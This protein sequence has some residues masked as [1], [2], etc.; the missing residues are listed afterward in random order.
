M[1]R[2]CIGSEVKG[3]GMSMVV[4]PYFPPPSTSNYHADSHSSKVGIVE[5][6]TC[7]E[8][9]RTYLTSSDVI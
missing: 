5:E 1:K 9:K 7:K 6:S 2:E 3:K 4:P 8:P